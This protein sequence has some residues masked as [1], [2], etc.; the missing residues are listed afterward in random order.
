MLHLEQTTSLTSSEFFVLRFVVLLQIT[1]ACKYEMHFLFNIMLNFRTASEQFDKDRYAVALVTM[2][3]ET[4]KKTIIHPSE[5]SMS[6]GYLLL[7]LNQSEV[8]V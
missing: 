5:T 8:F 1:P 3:G 2:D 4:M 6:N 7:S